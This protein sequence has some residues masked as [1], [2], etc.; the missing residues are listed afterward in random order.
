MDSFLCWIG[1]KKL[2]RNK[3]IERFPNSKYNRYVEVFGGAGWVLFAKD[4]HAKEEI[5]N[6][7]NKELVNLFRCAKYHAEELQREFELTLNSRETFND[8]KRQMNSKGLTDIQRAAKFYYLVKLS[9]GSRIRE[10]GLKKENIAVMKDY[11]LLVKE[12]LKNV[13]IENESFDK[14][15]KQYDAKDTLFYL[16][17][18]YASAENYY[19]AVFTWDHH[20]LL[21]ENLKSIKGK[22]LLSY[23]NHEEVKKWYK[24][25]K[26]EE[27]D[28]NNNLTTKYNKNRRYQ[29]LIITNY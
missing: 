2:L 20:K 17:P 28:R 16:D 6:D 21:L 15:I 23:N 24:D 3:I 26:I 27:I 7:I 19:D 25:F 9:Y 12:R 13:V 4:S 8:F 14:L 5:Y 1:G 18:P 29:E 11:L 22:F 10:Y